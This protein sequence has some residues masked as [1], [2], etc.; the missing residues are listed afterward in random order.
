MRFGIFSNSN[1]DIGYEV[2]IKIA[3]RLLSKN[4]APVFL[5]E[6]K[7][8]LLDD[9]N[10]VIYDDFK[11]CSLIISIGGDGTLLS[12]ISRF[13]ELD[14]PFVGVNKGSIG[15]LSEISCDVLD[16][17]IDKL[18]TKDYQILERAQLEAK[19]YDKN[20]NLKT[21]EI[22]LN[23]AVVTRGSKLHVINMD[24]TID[25]ALVEKF[26]GDG[27]IV[28]TP[29]GSTAYCLAAGGPILMPSMRNMIV[30]PLCSHTLNNSS[31]VTDYD[32]IIEIE[33]MGSETDAIFCADGRQAINIEPFDRV[34][35]SMCN[36]NVKTIVLGYS[37]FYNT[38]RKK[39]IARG[40][41]YESRKE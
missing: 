17:G 12:V 11:G 40:S 23:D 38:I 14:I 15:F 29:T 3:N 27:L 7:C 26:F 1:R 31:Y 21:T 9:I 34:C 8:S 13:N 16:E 35:I 5:N 19:V 22:C 25:G 18:I 4:V 32:S 24:L 37:S 2:A 28:S 39:I 6:Q 41:F 36:R 30:T 33:M 20:G 10:G